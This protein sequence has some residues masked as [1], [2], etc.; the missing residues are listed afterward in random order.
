MSTGERPSIDYDTFG[1]E[2]ESVLEA[3]HNRLHRDPDLPRLAAHPGAKSLVLGL[4]RAAMNSYSALKFLLADVPP[5]PARR[6]ELALAASPML[7]S[8]MEVLCAVVFAFGDLPKRVAWFYRSGYREIREEHDRLKAKYGGD[9]SWQSWLQS[10]ADMIRQVERDGGLC[11]EDIERP[12]G[13]PYWPIP[14]HMLKNPDLKEDRKAFLQ[15]LVDWLYRSLSQDMHLSLPG[16]VR[17]TMLLE[18]DVHQERRKT[19]LLDEKHRIM[20]AAVV[21]MTTIAS[22]LELEFKFGYAPRL[23][24][25]WGILRPH[26]EAAQEIYATYYASYFEDG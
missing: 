7:R 17:R 22:E 23:N 9:T 15:H 25:V 4:L 8:L 11:A 20:S 1:K 24:Y 18:R 16:L 12:G 3:I 14:N 10:R 6:P 2:L 5:N 21:L 13:I 19:L 26:D